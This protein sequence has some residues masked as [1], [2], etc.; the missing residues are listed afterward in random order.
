MIVGQSEIEVADTL[1]IFGL[2]LSRVRSFCLC[3][4]G[5]LVALHELE[6][7]SECLPIVLGSDV[8]VHRFEPLVHVFRFED[9]GA[10]A[11]WLAD[12][13]PVEML[14]VKSAEVNERIPIICFERLGNQVHVEFCVAFA[15]QLNRIKARLLHRGELRNGF[16]FLGEDESVP[17]A[18]DC[19]LHDLR[20]TVQ[21]AQ[22][23]R[24]NR[25]GRRTLQNSH[26][27]SIQKYF[28][29]QAPRDHHRL[30]LFPTM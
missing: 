3:S 28:L 16:L 14:D 15:C 11:A 4:F 26:L 8:E 30:L 2:L 1:Q 17:E 6:E 12:Q 7:G 5:K 21:Q 13:V 24:S 23:L 27:A 29:R 19:L 25:R 20:S 18:E 10:V 22:H 9:P